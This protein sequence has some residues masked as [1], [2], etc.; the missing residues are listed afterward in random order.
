MIVASKNKVG[1]LS[2]GMVRRLIARYKWKSSE[3]VLFDEPTA[4][5]DPEERVRFKSLLRKIKND[6]TIIISN[7]YCFGRK[8]NM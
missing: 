4:G 8:I 2:G 3:I 7:Y 6:K 5:L 1:S